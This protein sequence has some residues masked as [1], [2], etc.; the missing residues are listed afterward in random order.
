METGHIRVVVD[1]KGTVQ[2]SGFASDEEAAKAAK[3]LGISGHYPALQVDNLPPEKL[4]QISGRARILGFTL[5]DAAEAQGGPPSE[6]IRGSAAEIGGPRRGIS[7]R[8]LAL[9]FLIPVVALGGAVLRDHLD[10]D[11]SP[12]PS[13]SEAVQLVLSPAPRVS[14]LAS[15]INPP[16]SPYV[17]FAA[18]DWSRLAG[19]SA[20]LQGHYLKLRDL[21]AGSIERLLVYQPSTILSFRVNTWKSEVDALHVD[22]ILR[23]GI[24][25]DE[26]D[27]TM[28][29][30]P[31]DVT[32]TP[33]GYADGGD[34]VFDRKK[35][36]E[37]LER[38]VA[39]GQLQRTER[40]LRI[41]SDGYKVALVEEITPG[42][43]ALLED[44][45][46]A[47]GEEGNAG[48][49]LLFYLSFE[50]AFPWGTGEKPDRRQLYEEIGVAR[51]DGVESSGLY[52]RN[53]TREDPD[54]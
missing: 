20:I 50:E 7:K 19:A 10:R 45:L 2:I 1:G 42:L 17:S 51:L 41:T 22:E 48:E 34:I 54:S 38:F 16:D 43:S 46:A 30:Y 47:A 9:V 6:G 44:R 5:V 39:T 49:G 29:V 18:G 40:G 25:T 53:K 15:L 13:L 3:Q 37:D 12:V 27:V 23:D 21:K 11:Y 8:V 35:T 31:L 24:K 36:F 32:E 14:G 33:E 4:E 28:E 52:L 26:S